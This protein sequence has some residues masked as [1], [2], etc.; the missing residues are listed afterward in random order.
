MK[1]AGMMCSA[2]ELNLGSDHAKLLILEERPEIGTPIND[3]FPGGETVFDLAVTPNRPDAL[4]IIGIARELAALFHLEMKSRNSK[5]VPPRKPEPRP[6]WKVSPSR[7]KTSA[8]TTPP[9]ASAASKSPP[10]R[11]G[12][13]K[14]LR[15]SVC[16]RSTTSST[17]PTGS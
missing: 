13:R 1:S 4:S 3:V 16:A 15:P 14:I 5:T 9:T 2:K 7:K 17:S 12:S 11:S 6:Y 8:R 10:A